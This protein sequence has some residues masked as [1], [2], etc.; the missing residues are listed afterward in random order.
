[1]KKH[2]SWDGAGLIC[3]LQLPALLAMSDQLAVGQG[4]RVIEIGG[5]WQYVLR[6]SSLAGRAVNGGNAAA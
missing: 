1:M 5:W 6:G 4:V 3:E 2:F